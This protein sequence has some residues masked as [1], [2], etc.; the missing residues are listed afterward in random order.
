MSYSTWGC[1]HSDMTE[2]QTNKQANK[3]KKEVL[4]LASLITQVLKN[5]PEI[6]ETPVGVLGLEDPLEKG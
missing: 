6:Q 2:R 1:K 5:L 3:Q 4:N